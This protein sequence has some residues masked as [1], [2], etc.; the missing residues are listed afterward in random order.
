MGVDLSE[1]VPKQPKL[2]R[3]FS[4]Q[5][6]AV[7][8]YNTI[9][10]FLAIIRQPDGSPLMDS[11][12]R[13]TSHLSGLLYRNLNLLEAGIRPVYVFD[14]KPHELKKGTIEE[15]AAIKEKAQAEYEAA[16]AEGDL[17]RARSKAQQTSRITKDMVE[18]AKRLLGLIGIPVV[19]APMDGEGEAA[20]L[21]QRG[22]ASAVASQD[23]DSLLFGSP[24]LV[25]NLTVTGRRKLPR[26]QVYINVEPER[27]ELPAVL[28]ALSL[29]REQLVEMCILMGTDFNEGIRGIGP[30][31]AQKLMSEHGTL[32]RVIAAKNY[33]I[34]QWQEVRRIFLEPAVEDP[35]P[36]AFGEPQ[37]ERIVDLLVGEHDF[38]KERVESPLR[39][40]VE[41]RK[42]QKRQGSQLRLDKWF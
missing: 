41:M 5:T 30:K 36:P 6:V 28:S 38:S 20:F 24:V 25:R 9:Y 14:G 10:Q 27:M 15:R 26:K 31:K 40:L 29:T 32:E 4:G 7:D 23:F 37:V 18:E 35:G 39:R 34:P 8:A 22:H 2:I 16:L 1:L 12:K 13:V 21:V 42:E 3:D 33:D 17:E 19:Q 11:R